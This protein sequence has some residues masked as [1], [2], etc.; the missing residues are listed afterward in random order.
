MGPQPSKSGRTIGALTGTWRA[1]GP[2]APCWTNKTHSFKV[3]FANYGS[4][5]GS[6]F[7][8]PLNGHSSGRRTRPCR[9]GLHFTYSYLAS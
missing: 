5:Q 7:S 8:S 9:T 1:S 6:G 4:C 3:G 2:S